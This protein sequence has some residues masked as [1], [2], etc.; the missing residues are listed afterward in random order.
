MRACVCAWVR[1]CVCACVRVCMCACVHAC[2]RVC[3]CACMCVCLHVC[4]L[5]VQC[6]QCVRVVCGCMRARVCACVRACVRASEAHIIEHTHQKT[7]RCVHP[8]CTILT[9]STKRTPQFHK[10]TYVYTPNE[11]YVSKSTKIGCEQMH[12]IHS[13][14]TSLH[15]KIPEY[16][17]TESFF[18]TRHLCTH[19]RVE[20]N[21]ACSPSKTHT[22]ESTDSKRDP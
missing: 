19:K 4:E 21:D 6:V 20:R 10:K 7:K 8:I 22:M 9:I 17:K 5:C 12:A 14:H 16:T 2:A 18:N 3:T 11:T 15:H 13:R 1:A